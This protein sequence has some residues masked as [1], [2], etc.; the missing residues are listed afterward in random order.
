MT[1]KLVNGIHRYLCDSLQHILHVVCCLPHHDLPM[2]ML[3]FLGFP[4]IQEELKKR[5]AEDFGKFHRPPHPDFEHFT[6]QQ[7][8]FVQSTVKQTIKLLTENGGNTL[9]IEEY[10]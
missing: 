3:D 5:M 8:V 6:P 10:L 9:G 1:L 2:V 4:Y 7:N